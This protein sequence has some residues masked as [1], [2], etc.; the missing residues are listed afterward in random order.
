MIE[1]RIANESDVAHLLKMINGSY[2]PENS[3]VSWSNESKY[4]S[5][6]RINAP[7]LLET[8]QQPNSVVLVGIN[9]NALVSCVLIEQIEHAAKIGLLT[10]DIAKQQLGYG[11]A[12]LHAAEKYAF[13][14]FGSSEI[15]MHVLQIRSELID[16][17]MRRGYN[18]TGVVRDYPVHLGVGR[19]LIDNLKYE[20]LSKLPSTVSK[21]HNNPLHGIT[22]EAI[23]TALVAHYS[24]SGLAERIPVNCFINDPS[25]KSSLKFLRKTQWARDKVEMLYLTML[26]NK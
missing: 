21:Q 12:T 24:W 16:F 13:K 2:R 10:V 7:Q 3:H 20:V 15:K 25:T 14:T 1:F 17:Y 8:L 19:P 11:K 23:V 22:L 4:M 26:Q 6:D 18:R 5:G 9:D